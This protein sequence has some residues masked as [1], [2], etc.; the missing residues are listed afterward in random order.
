M[1]GRG[2][3]GGVGDDVGDGWMEDGRSFEW[4]D[5]LDGWL[6]GQRAENWKDA[7]NSYIL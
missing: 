6:D 7:N 2:R 4:I 1:G 3:E 5:N